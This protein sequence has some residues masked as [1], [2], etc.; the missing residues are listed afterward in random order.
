MYC[1]ECIQEF[2]YD[3]YFTVLLFTSHAISVLHETTETSTSQNVARDK[4]LH[5]CILVKHF[6]HASLTGNNIFTFY[7]NEWRRDS[8]PSFRTNITACVGLFSLR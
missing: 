6:Y 1:I 3:Y 8:S 2:G 7:N 4:F 5:H